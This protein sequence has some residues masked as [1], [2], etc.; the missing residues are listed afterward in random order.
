[1]AR[2]LMDTTLGDPGEPQRYV[3]E[4]L[5]SHGVRSIGVRTEPLV[6]R[7]SGNV[8]AFP[9]GLPSQKWMRAR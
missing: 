9:T 5:R 8:V 6:N 4:E 2:L 7:F 1:M 3:D